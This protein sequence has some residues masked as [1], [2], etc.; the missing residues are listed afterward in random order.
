MKFS[1]SLSKRG[2]ALFLAL[3]MCISLLPTTALSLEAELD[4]NA[5]EQHDSKLVCEIEEHTHDEQCYM[6]GKQELVCLLAEDSGHTHDEAC[7]DPEGVLAC[8]QEEHEAHIH[9]MDCYTAGEATLSCDK[10]EHTH[11]ET[12]YAASAGGISIQSNTEPGDTDSAVTKTFIIS[13]RILDYPG[14]NAI[15]S[16]KYPMDLCYDY[17]YEFNGQTYTGTTTSEKLEFG[18]SD[19]QVLDV[20][21]SGDGTPTQVTLTVKNNAIDGYKFR[22][23]QFYWDS[24]WQLSWEESISFSV[25]SVN[26]I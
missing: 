7:Y 11:I 14:G 2:L 8:G 21:V 16:E 15:I 25:R 13:T 17:S 5:S 22:C 12:C 3:M 24:A 20:L 6:N 4:S 23:Q 18:V 9:G 26:N 19:R 1:K 10:T